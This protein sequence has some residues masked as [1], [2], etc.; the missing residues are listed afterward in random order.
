MNSQTSENSSVSHNII[1]E[2]DKYTP[3]VYLF[4]IYLV[5][6]MQNLNSLT[7]VTLHNYPYQHT[8]QKVHINISTC[9]ENVYQWRHNENVHH[10]KQVY[11]QILQNFVFIYYSNFSL[12]F[13]INRP[14]GL[15]CH[16]IW[17]LTC[18]ILYLSCT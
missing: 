9:A 12:M 7:L 8:V 13:K 6:I 5:M 2:S 10:Y 11:C 17:I 3:F 15:I 1:D 14:L 16:A 4:I 18:I